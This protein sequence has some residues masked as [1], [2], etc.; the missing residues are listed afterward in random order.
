MAM[1]S[2][3]TLQHPT[4]QLH[5]AMTVTVLIH[6]MAPD[7]QIEDAVLV[8]RRAFEGGMDRAVSALRCFT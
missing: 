6:A 5:S 3:R 4:G 2:L 1:A 8:C 7:E